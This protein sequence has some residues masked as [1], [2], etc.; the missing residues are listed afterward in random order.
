METVVFIIFLPTK[1]KARMK[2]N[3]IIRLSQT[4]THPLLPLLFSLT[5]FNWKHIH[6]HNSQYHSTTSKD[7]FPSLQR[8]WSSKNWRSSVTMSSYCSAYKAKCL[9]LI[10]SIHGRGVIPGTSSQGMRIA[11]NGSPNMWQVT[12]A[13]WDRTWSNWLHSPHIASSRAMA[14]IQRRISLWKYHT[15][16]YCMD[17]W[18][19]FQPPISKCFK[20]VQLLVT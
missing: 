12:E 17:S 1:K 2:N 14:F 13:P 20:S 15:S 8:S 11:W 16:Q 18:H 4:T 9:K 6:Q 10:A 3:K 7:L 5:I 19:C